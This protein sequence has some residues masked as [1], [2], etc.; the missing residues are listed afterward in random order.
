MT[1]LRCALILFSFLTSLHAITNAPAILTSPTPGSTLSGTSATFVWTTGTGVTEYSLYIGTT[2]HAHDIAFFNPKSANSYS[3]SNLPS[4]GGTFYVDLFSRISN[5]WQRQSYTFIATGTA[6][7]ATM[8]A[9]ATGATLAGSAQTFT[10][11]SGSGVTSYSLY[12]GTTHGAHDLYF[13]NTTAT[14]ASVTGLPMDGRPVYVTLYSLIAGV[15]QYHAYTFIAWA[16]GLTSPK[17]GSKLDSTSTTFTWNL[18]TG[19][20]DYSLYVGT[21]P[22]KHNL[23]FFTTRSAS[24]HTVSG[25]PSNGGTFYV[26]YFTRKNGVWN[27]TSYQYIASGTPGAATI[28]TPTPASTLGGTSQT[29]TW[30]A[31]TGVT[32]Y[33]LYVGTAPRTHD[34]YFVNTTTGNSATV[35]GLP[36][37]AS[38]L[39]VTLYSLVD[40]VWRAN[41]YTYTAW[42]LTVK[43]IEVTG[44][45][46]E[47]AMDGTLQLTATATYS[48]GSTKN[49][50]DTAWWSSTGEEFATVL[51][52]GPNSG[53]VTGIYLGAANIH[54]SVGAVASPS[55]TVTVTGDLPGQWTWITGSNEKDRPGVYGTLGVASAGNSPGARQGAGMWRD[56][57]GKLW[58]FGGWGT[59][60]ILDIFLINDLWSFDPATKLWTW[61]SG[62]KSVNHLGIY[63]TKGVPAT[64]NTPGSRTQPV[65]WTDDKGNLWLFGGTGNDSHGGATLN[66]LWK[67]D[68]ATHQWT[69]MSGSSDGNQPG[70]YG[71]KGVP[72]AA[73][74][75]G[76]RLLSAGWTD[77]GGKLWLFGGFSFADGKLNDLWMFD[78]TTTQWTWVSGSSG[79][80]DPGVYGTLGVPD[81]ANVPP[82]RAAF[83]GWIDN[84]G[85]FWIFGGM[86]QSGQSDIYINDLWRFDPSTKM[87]TWMSGGNSQVAGIYGTLGIPDAANV[88]GA[89]AYDVGWTDKN[90]KLWLF[91]GSGVD[92]T[93]SSAFLDDL[94][95]W[96]PATSKWTWMSGWKT[97]RHPGVWGTKG[98]TAP[99]NVPDTRS[100][101]S[102]VADATGK[103]WLFGGW[104]WDFEMDMTP[105]QHNDLWNYQL[106]PPSM[107]EHQTEH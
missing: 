92:S 19:I 83:P 12:I 104:G 94:W 25:L 87:W 98:V 79:V 91:G 54:A 51:N 55:F 46:S 69:W 99:T 6:V 96:D 37:D 50:T 11:S 47:V 82:A 38:T 93:G 90:G 80:N 53:L 22:H 89:R 31:G 60:E 27:R 57:F 59:G 95:Q 32:E 5:T 28:L 70:V 67:Y 10:W 68:P 8:S 9:P 64:E 41:A 3:A 26:D 30:S 85:R 52:G 23:E 73:N 58:I 29:F 97:I 13:K 2:P 88:P 101:A 15:W 102:G 18:G 86:T 106:I 36:N 35:T 42:S 43:S 4:H 65:T 84:A 7:S 14:S 40:G 21:T 74:H 17:P 71:T 20:T 66:D 75:P 56:K 33:S 77:S 16:P 39:Y 49:I 76:A 78:P 45:S 63:G 100:G 44:L 24:S 34:L 72:A 103:L 62:S 48:D 1:L 107:P 105:G 81:A 61:M